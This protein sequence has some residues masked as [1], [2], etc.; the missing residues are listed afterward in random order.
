MPASI[1]SGIRGISYLRS[2]DPRFFGGVIGCP[3]RLDISK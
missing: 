3:F 1:F 2:E